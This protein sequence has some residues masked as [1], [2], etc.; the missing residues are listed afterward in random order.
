MVHFIT[1]QLCVS[2]GTYYKAKTYFLLLEVVQYKGRVTT[3]ITEQMS[4]FPGDS[5]RDFEKNP[6]DVCIACVCEMN[7][8]FICQSDKMLQ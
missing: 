3:S 1:V 5:G 7:V 2:F 4:R 6:G 8:L